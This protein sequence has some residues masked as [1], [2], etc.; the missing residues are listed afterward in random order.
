MS[1]KNIFAFGLALVL[2][3]S[4]PIWAL[5][6]CGGGSGYLHDQHLGSSGHMGAGQ[7]GM[8]GSQAPVQMDPNA[9]APGNFAPAPP[10]AG[11]AAPQNSGGYG[12][13]QMMNQGGMSSGHSNH[14]QH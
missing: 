6:Q 4:L 10:A 2:A 8:Y 5:A 13:G 11:Y 1:Q 7:R 14:P 12:S 3:I 9:A